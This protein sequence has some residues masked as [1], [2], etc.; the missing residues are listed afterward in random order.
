L[1][2][3]IPNVVF[4]GGAAAVPFVLLWLAGIAVAGLVIL[5]PSLRSQTSS[6]LLQRVRKSW[7]ALAGSI[8]LPALAEGLALAVSLPNVMWHRRLSALLSD[9]DPCACEAASDLIRATDEERQRLEAR[10]AEC[11]T[12]RAKE[13]EEAHV[14]RCMDAAAHAE[15]GSLTPEE[16]EAL[17]DRAALAKRIA[18]KAVTVSDLT[19]VGKNAVPCSTTAAGSRF[20]TLYAKVAV[21]ST[22]AWKQL[23]GE[24]MPASDLR[25]HVKS[26]AVALPEATAQGFNQHV[27][28]VAVAAVR[29]GKRS[30]DLSNGAALCELAAQLKQ[31]SSST[32]VY[33]LAK[34]E[35]FKKSEEAAR[36]AAAAVEEAKA[37]READAIQ[38]KA[39]RCEAQRNMFSYCLARCD[40]RY[41]ENYPCFEACNVRTPQPDC[42]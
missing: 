23:T 37:K 13:A 39:K 17:E 34:N 18:S 11:A 1:L 42:D 9:P 29:D 21:T 31:P 30:A 41:G 12:K 15:A 5:T 7:L 14:K 33:L 24:N 38:A 40:Q 4:L 27:E 20:W 2:L 25:D 35:T 36:K 32:C 22:E 10:K 28:E 19:S 26:G 16:I 8:L 3:L 6:E